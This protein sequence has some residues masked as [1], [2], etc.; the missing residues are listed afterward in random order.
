MM[1][2]IARA[3]PS[4]RAGGEVTE[5]ER[6]AA[7]PVLVT[8]RRLRLPADLEAERAR[9]S[10]QPWLALSGLLVVVPFALVLA[11]SAGSLEASLRLLD[12]LTTFGLPVIVMVSFW[13]ED[14]PGTRLRRGAGS[15]DALFI[16][17]VAVAL[18]SAGQLVA[19]G[20]IDPRGL[21]SARATVAELPSYPTLM[22]LAGTMFVVM[23][24]LTLVGEGWPL[25]GLRRAP[26]GLL[27]LVVAGAVSVLLY[28][29]LVSSSP[30]AGSSYRALRGPMPASHYG[31]AVLCVGAWQSLFYISA[32]GAPFNGIR[33]RGLR[34]V[35]AHLAVLGCG[36]ATYG[37][38]TQLFRAEP[39]RVAAL[40]ASVIAASVVWGMLAEGW[41]LADPEGHGGVVALAVAIP[42]GLAFFAILR[43]SAS[44][45][46]WDRVSA[47]DW[48]AYTA[49]N[50]VGGAV[51]LH[52][53]VG[54]RWPLRLLGQADEG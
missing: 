22:P 10:V 26:G 23:L 30:P 25:R 40:A 47:D 34:L 37:A 53:A 21:F 19:A 4:R 48:V 46:H 38:A 50:A 54:R 13:W 20:R 6:A 1:G 44:N 45:A 27:A 35:V 12:P 28:S 5:D 9:L 31:A 18:T 3:K 16:T 43:L 33:R 14:W 17:I 24:Q 39:D 36:V 51:I 2:R 7:R 29:T 8:P 42:L 49:A 11:L 52:V 41:P 32:R 15:A